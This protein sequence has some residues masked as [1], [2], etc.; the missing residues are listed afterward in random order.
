[1]VEEQNRLAEIAEQL[2]QG[3]QPPPETVRTLL[4]WFGAQRRGYYISEIIDKALT[5]RGIKTQPD[6]RYAY[7]DSPVAFVSADGATAP[8]PADA[9]GQ[10]PTDAIV[11]DDQTSDPAPPAELIAAPIATVGGAVEDPTYRIG[12]LAA[13]NNPPARVAPN[14]TLREAVTLML[15]N[16]FTQL[17]VM[18]NN[19]DVKGVVSWTSIGARLAMDNKSESVQH[20]MEQPRLL[21]ADV[22]LF[23][24]IATI[25]E[26]GYVLIRDAQNNI[27]GIV[28]TSD[29][30]FQF[31]QLGEPFLLIGEIENHI[32][33]MVDGKFTPEELKENRSPTDTEREVSRVSDLTFGEYQWLLQKPENWERLGIPLD[34]KAFTE[35]LDKVRLIR[36]DVMHFDPD[37]L[38]PEDIETL[39]NFVQFLQRLREITN[40]RH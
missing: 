36:N 34:R 29:L 32:R 3:N 1:M 27:S 28:T 25:V 15:S 19:R 39:R 12:K 35:Q 30:S 33:R 7:I 26:N 16:D 20:Y 23:A 13:A 38:S 18:Q 10:K 2:N 24:A 21:S 11:A 14:S 4:K 8:T 31:G 5:Q 37:G 22:S 17:P 40:K 9:P 6:F